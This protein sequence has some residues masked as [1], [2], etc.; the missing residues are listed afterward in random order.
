MDKRC[1]ESKKTISL[2]QL[3]KT[4]KPTLRT[5]MANNYAEERME[6]IFTDYHTLLSRNG[7][8]WLITDNHKVAVKHVRFAISPPTVFDRLTLGL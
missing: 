6:D 7:I 2:A 1:V 3:G 8:A 4:V 5:N